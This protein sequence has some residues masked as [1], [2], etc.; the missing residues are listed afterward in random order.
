MSSPSQTAY[1][2]LWCAHPVLQSILALAMWRRGLHKQFRVFFSYILLQIVIFGVT[3]PLWRSGNY[4]WFFWTYWAGAAVNAIVSF[5]IIHEIFLD[6]FRPYHSLKDLGT[7]IF[8]WAGTVMLMVAAV[9]AFSNSPKYAPVVHAVTTLQR[10]VRFVQFGLIVFLILFSRYLGV[11]RR[12]HSFGIAL[13]FG[14]FAG[15]ELLLLALSSGGLLH[16]QGLAVFNTIMFNLAIVIWVVYVFVPHPARDASMNTFQTERWEE[17]L[18]DLQHP[19][20]SDSLIPMFE[21]MVERALSRNSNV[22]NMQPPSNA[23][24]PPNSAGPPPRSVAATASA[25]GRSRT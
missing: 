3:F 7:I 9:V 12:Q 8:R 15:T 20:A 5:K 2:I 11:S 23:T 21:G 16:Q 22:A 13:G 18:A 17:S 6:V 25:G 19:P 14:F 4:E 24:K 1:Q 10:S